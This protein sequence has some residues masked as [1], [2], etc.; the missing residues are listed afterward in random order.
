LLGL[1]KDGA[2]MMPHC[3]RVIQNREKVLWLSADVAS[4]MMSSFGFLP[5]VFFL[6]YSTTG[7]TQERAAVII[8]WPKWSHEFIILF[9]SL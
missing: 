6:F 7:K 4:S 1:A 9:S 3:H 2:V 8:S 5:H